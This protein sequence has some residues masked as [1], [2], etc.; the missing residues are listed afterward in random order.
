MRLSAHTLEPVRPLPTASSIAGRPLPMSSPRIS[1]EPLRPSDFPLSSKITMSDGRV[2]ANWGSALACSSTVFAAAVAALPRASLAFT[3]NGSSNGSVL[4]RSASQRSSRN[5][6][7]WSWA[8]AAVTARCDSPL[9]LTSPM[10]SR[11]NMNEST[12]TMKTMTA[13]TAMMVARTERS[14]PG[15]RVQSAARSP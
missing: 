10:V 7:T 12:L 2:V 8:T 5:P 3:L 6:S 9:L 11:I 1:F 13:K 15:W 14:P 4:A